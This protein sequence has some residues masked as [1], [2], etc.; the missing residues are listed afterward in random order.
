MDHKI[1]SPAAFIVASHTTYLMFYELHKVYN[2]IILRSVG[3]CIA[4]TEVGL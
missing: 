3:D 2:E 1:D 4:I